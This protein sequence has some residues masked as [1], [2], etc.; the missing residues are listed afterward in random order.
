VKKRNFKFLVLLVGLF[1]SIVLTGCGGGEQTGGSETTQ[2]VEYKETGETKGEVAQGVTDSEILVGHLGPQ[3]GPA[4]SYD[5]VR[6]T[7]ETYFA[8]VNENGG[9]DGR[10]LK[11][12]AYDDQYQPA[13]TVQLAKRLVEEDKVFAVL[14]NV[15][16][17]CNAAAQDYYVEKGI[18]T[19]MLS[20]GAKQF[21]DPPIK[22]FMGTNTF[23]YAIEAKVFLDYAVNELGAKNIS[24]AYQNDG[25]G[26][27]GYEALMKEVEKYEGLTVVEEV[28]FLATDVE[29]SSQAKKLKDANADA[30][31]AFAIPSPAA[32]L[33][34][35][36]YK[37]GTDSPFI[38]SSVG[39]ND[40][41][42]FKLAGEKE[43]NGM[44]T[45]AT[46]PMPGQSDDESLKLYEELYS[47]A[48]PNDPLVGVNQLGWG[49]A[50]VFVEALKRTEG[51]LTWDNFLKAF[52][53]FEG[54]DGSMYDSVTFSENNHYGITSLFMTKAQDGKIVPISDVIQYDPATGEIK[55]K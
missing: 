43:W 53:T 44:I 10:K 41:N 38:V 36:L 20:T 48:Y 42:Q 21:V 12:V 9:I 45:S 54:W 32:N 52:Y 14:A 29:F 7:L 1:I 3:T 24:V 18:P 19:L 27:E 39:G 4:A 33:K 50:E 8:Y 15:C 6:K 34:K 11:L 31:I 40:P 51:D 35:A 22:N 17:A 37:V 16:T 5:L 49:A 46:V 26:K 28:N 30:I 2:K 55:Y 23:N 13:K 25:F 47:K